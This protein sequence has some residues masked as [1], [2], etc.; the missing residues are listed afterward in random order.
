MCCQVINYCFPVWCDFAVE[1]Q[2]LQSSL[3][4]PHFR[5]RT[6]TPDG[7]DLL[8]GDERAETGWSFG[9]D[10]VE[11]GL[12]LVELFGFGVGRRRDV[13]PGQRHQAVEERPGGAGPTPHRA[14]SP[15]RLLEDRPQV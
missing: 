4:P 15:L 5:P 8:P 2:L 9:E 3:D 13:C 10:L 1:H 6:D 14:V 12:Q 7:H 11:A